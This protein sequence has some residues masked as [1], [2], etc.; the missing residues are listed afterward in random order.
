MEDATVLRQQRLQ[1]L[2]EM[3]YREHEHEL[4]MREHE[5]E[6][7]ARQL[8]RERI[9][10]LNLRNAGARQD[11][12]TS[13]SSG[14]I[15]AAARAAPLQRPRYDSAS[16]PYP[17][18]PPYSSYQQ[19]LASPL[20]TSINQR[21]AS[22]PTSPNG[23]APYCGCE[24]CSVSKYRATVDSPLPSP[25]D[26]RPSEPLIS[27][28][29]LEKPKGW[30]RRLS[31]PVMNTAFSSDSKKGLGGAGFRSSLDLTSEDG[32]LQSI[33]GGIRNRSATNL[34]RR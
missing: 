4:R 27:L 19:H 3:E 21:P 34:A 12:Y 8:E 9:H 20:Q 17:Q 24:A 18:Q 15:S 31:M 16:S 1:E 29:A 11:G 33:T 25:R 10:L 23:H 28:R 32:R 6:Q 14:N 7:Q 2:E 5:I 30:I 13:D 22:Q 26:L